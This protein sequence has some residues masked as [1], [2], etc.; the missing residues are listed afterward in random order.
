LSRP[1]V[2]S[3]NF[4]FLFLSFLRAGTRNVIPQIF[5][6]T[7]HPDSKHSLLSLFLILGTVAS[8]AGVW[9]SRGGRA[10]GI[11]RIMTQRA[12]PCLLVAIV[13]VLFLGLFGTTHL[14]LYFA[15]FIALKFTADFLYGYLDDVFVKSCTT[16]LLKT[17]V[18]TVL[19]YQL[20]GI[21]AA[22]FVFSF[23][24]SNQVVIASV[25]GCMGLASGLALTSGTSR[26]AS[27]RSSESPKQESRI[28]RV[29]VLFLLYSGLILQTIIVFTTIVIFLLG[30]Y[31]HLDDAK[32]K[33]GIFIGATS[34]VA[35]VTIFAAQA[36][37]RSTTTRVFNPTVNLIVAALFFASFML[38]FVRASLS[39]AYVMTI[40]VLAGI[41]YGLFLGDT[42]SHASTISKAH[43]KPGLLSAYNNL[44]NFASL[45]GYGVSL[46][47]ALTC[48]QLGL[49]YFKVMLAISMA[50]SALSVGI[51]L[52]IR[53]SVG[54]QLTPGVVDG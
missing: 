52:L 43:N 44:T 47:M 53:R 42:R 39:F 6:L 14:V 24:Y 31:Y 26:P 37:R 16:T 41:A 19:L 54:L 15:I 46:A 36:R 20:L 35:I 28:D 1:A 7:H 38:F 4:V 33:G 2:Y 10:A 49:D 45:I 18:Q 50:L 8:I 32:I 3:R 22:P 27:P 48:E 25:I 21:T 29:D 30:D 23:Y 12:L 13:T 17:H 34:I 9:S 51:I 40:A 11:R 5:F